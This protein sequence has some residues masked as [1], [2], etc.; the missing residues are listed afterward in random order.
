MRI[1]RRARIPWRLLALLMLVGGV[2][3]A[4]SGTRAASAAS[5]PTSHAARPLVGCAPCISSL[6]PEQNGNVKA[7]ASGK[8]TLTFTAQMVSPFVQF[9]LTLDGTAVDGKKIQVTTNDPLQPTGTYTAALSAGAHTASVEADDAD[10]SEAVFVGWNF[11]VDASAVTPVATKTPVSNSGGTSTPTTGNGGADT[12]GSSSG[13]PP[14][15]T[16]SIVLFAIAG[17]GLLVM[18]FIAGMWFNGRQVFNRP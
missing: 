16:M 5:L 6:D 14:T 2:A 7:D 4:A 15:R 17:V 8:V 13:I 18:A 1:L 3:L 9:V 10:G 12:G 11:T